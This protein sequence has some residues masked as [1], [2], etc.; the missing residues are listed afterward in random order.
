MAARG[1]LTVVRRSWVMMRDA[2]I[3]VRDGQAR[4]VVYVADPKGRE[5]FTPKKRGE[6]PPMLKQFV[7][8][9]VETVQLATGAKLELAAEPTWSPRMVLRSVNELSLHYEI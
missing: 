8:Q 2:S 9:L 7:D 3:A 1:A 5:P 6:R 4:A